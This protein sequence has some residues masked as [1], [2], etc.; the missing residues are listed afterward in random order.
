MRC[1][2]WLCGQAVPVTMTGRLSV[3]RIYGR[4]RWEFCPNS[5]SPAEGQQEGVAS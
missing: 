4:G 3:H 5:G 1:Q 2:C